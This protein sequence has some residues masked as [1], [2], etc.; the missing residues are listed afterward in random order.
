MGDR[1][2]RIMDANR[3]LKALQAKDPETASLVQ[4]LVLVALGQMP[5]SNIVG[6][7]DDIENDVPMLQRAEG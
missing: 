1:A 6:L 7:V 2:R 4:N 3:Q 5:A